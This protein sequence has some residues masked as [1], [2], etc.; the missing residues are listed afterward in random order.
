MIQTRENS[1]NPNTFTIETDVILDKQNTGLC[2]GAKDKNNFLM[3]QINTLDG[4]NGKVLLR[5]HVCKNGQ[6]VDTKN[7][8]ITKAIGYNASEIFGKKIHMKIEVKRRKN[9]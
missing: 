1:S 2:F 7:L 8:D 6:W 5:P 4:G 3:W 9:H